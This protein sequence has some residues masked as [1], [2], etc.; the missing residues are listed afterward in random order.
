MLTG[1]NGG[2]IY[3]FIGC[4]LPAS[5]I[6]LNSIKELEPDQKAARNSNNITE[7]LKWKAHVKKVI[8]FETLL[9]TEFE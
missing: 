6:K 1:T 2:Q 8:T 3:A 5:K 4:I 7:E 9:I